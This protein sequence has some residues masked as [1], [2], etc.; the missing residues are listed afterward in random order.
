MSIDMYMNLGAIK[1]ESTDPTHVGWVD[2]LAF[3]WGESEAIQ[4]QAGGGVQISKPNISDLSITKYIDKASVPLLLAGVK[5]SPPIPTATLVCRQNAGA[6]PYIFLTYTLTTVFV[7]SVSEAGS[8]GEDKLTENVSFA[9][10]K[11]QW[12]YRAAAG[13]PQIVGGYDQVTGQTT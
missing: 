3:S 6:T 4:Q 9:F 5:N 8:G 13:G 1:G 11:I 10:Q 2:V 7:T 12:A